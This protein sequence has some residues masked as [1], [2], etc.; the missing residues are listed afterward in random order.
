M[1]FSDTVRCLLCESRSICPKNWK[2]PLGGVFASGNGRV[3]AL[4][5]SFFGPQ[6]QNQGGAFTIGTNAS[7]Y[8]ASG[9]F[10]GQKVG[11]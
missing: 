10:A 11:P 9:I 6:A 7:S 4:T 5:G 2:P 1:S 8:K 3:G